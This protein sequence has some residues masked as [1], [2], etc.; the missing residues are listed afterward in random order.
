M[1]LGHRNETSR[2]AKE[3]VIFPDINHTSGKEN[4]V[5]LC[6]TELILRHYLR[7]LHNY[8]DSSYVLRVYML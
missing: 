1:S 6:F 3:K 7:T 2:T 5:A 4:D 8:R